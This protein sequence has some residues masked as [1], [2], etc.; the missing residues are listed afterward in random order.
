VRETNCCMELLG[1]VAS[2]LQSVYT[3][4]SG[5]GVNAEWMRSGCGVDADL[6]QSGCTVDAVGEK[7]MHS[8]CGVDAKWMRS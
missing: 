2:P 4:Q 8:G 3:V 7:W 1:S 6:M 5:S